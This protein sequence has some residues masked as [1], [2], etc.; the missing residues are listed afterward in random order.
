LIFGLQSVRGMFLS[1]NELLECE[2]IFKLYGYYAVL[3]GGG[4][5]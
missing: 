4:Q 5:G 3:L 1:A 2:Y